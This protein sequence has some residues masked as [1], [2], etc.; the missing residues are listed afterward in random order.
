MLN[1]NLIIAGIVGISTLLLLPGCDW[2]KNMRTNKSCSSQDCAAGSCAQA[3]EIAVVTEEVATLDEQPSTEN[4][5][6]AFADAV[7]SQEV[8]LNDVASIVDDVKE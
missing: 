7:E 4:A 2:I 3:E 8:A 1:K 5:E 6:V